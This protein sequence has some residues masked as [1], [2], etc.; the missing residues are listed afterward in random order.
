MSLW[1]F[2]W[3]VWIILKSNLILNSVESIKANKDGEH[4]RQ[5]YDFPTLAISVNR[6]L[7][8]ILMLQYIRVDP[9]VQYIS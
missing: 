8:L 4:R 5:G 6:A 3:K 1:D 9:E 2:I 7:F